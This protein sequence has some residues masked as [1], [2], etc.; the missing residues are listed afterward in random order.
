[1]GIVSA[2]EGAGVER[3]EVGCGGAS[4]GRNEEVNDEVRGEEARV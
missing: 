3:V 4:A 1:M 2:G